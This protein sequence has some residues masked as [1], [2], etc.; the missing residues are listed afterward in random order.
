[1][2]SGPNQLPLRGDPKKDKKTEQTRLNSR[3]KTLNKQRFKQGLPLL[4][5]SYTKEEIQAFDP[6]LKYYT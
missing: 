4:T 3:R 6:P 5:G 2:K 1:L